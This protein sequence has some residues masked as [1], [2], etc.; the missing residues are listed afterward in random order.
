MTL[1]EPNA[2]F[3]LAVNFPFPP[4]LSPCAN[5]RPLVICETRFIE[6]SENGMLTKPD[7]ENEADGSSQFFF[8]AFVRG[9]GIDTDCLIQSHRRTNFDVSTCRFFFSDK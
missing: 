8:L 4:F 3:T 2:F 1:L 6:S 5:Y 9:K 7:G